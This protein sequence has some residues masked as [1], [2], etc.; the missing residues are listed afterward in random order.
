MDWLPRLVT[1]HALDVNFDLRPNHADGNGGL[2]AGPTGT[3]NNTVHQRID[4]S[5]GTGGDTSAAMS[6]VPTGHLYVIQHAAGYHTDGT[7]RGC[8]LVKRSGAVSYELVRSASTAGLTTITVSGP[9]VLKAGEYIQYIAF[10]L[11]ASVNARLI[12]VGYDVVL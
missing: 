4:T 12:V 7:A 5:S 8:W 1:P 11:A 6:P 10:A 2:F 3:Y 9:I